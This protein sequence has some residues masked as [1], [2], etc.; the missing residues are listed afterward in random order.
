MNGRKDVFR[1]CR[2]LKHFATHVSTSA[3]IYCRDMYKRAPHDHVLQ[4]MPFD[5][6]NLNAKYLQ[7]AMTTAVEDCANCIENAQKGR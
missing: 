3:Q 7:I 2:H 6:Q 1:V 5:V 4:L